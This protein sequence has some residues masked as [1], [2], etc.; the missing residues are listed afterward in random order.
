MALGN[1][2][3]FEMHSG[4]KLVL[5]V[6]VKDALGVAVNLTGATFKWQLSK[7]DESGSIPL[8]K[9]ETPILQKDDA[10]LGGVVIFDAPTGRVNVTLLEANTAALRGVFYHELQMVQAS[11]TSTV[12]FGKATIYRDL[13]Q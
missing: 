12:L 3:D 9:S 11:A 10:G 1:Q 7:L 5:E 8:P 4:D 2:Q 13:I 6:T